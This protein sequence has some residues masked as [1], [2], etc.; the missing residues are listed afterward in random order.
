M[1]IGVVAF[2][3]SCCLFTLRQITFA[4]VS[5]LNIMY[6]LFRNIILRQY[7]KTVLSSKCALYALI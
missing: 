7:L 1:F 6:V 5:F 4:I 2:Q 3:I